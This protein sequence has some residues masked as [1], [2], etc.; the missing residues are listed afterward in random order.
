MSTTKPGTSFTRT[1]MIVAQLFSCLEG[2]KKGNNKAMG[3]QKIDAHGLWCEDQS[4]LLSHKRCA[5]PQIP[6]EKGQNPAL[7]D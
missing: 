7:G 4:C 1:H 5:F 2:M 6:P 3:E